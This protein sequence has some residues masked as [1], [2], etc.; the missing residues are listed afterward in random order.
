MWDLNNYCGKFWTIL[1]EQ[2][3]WR[4]KQNK[5]KNTATT[6]TKNK[7]KPQTKITFMLW[8]E[9][10]VFGNTT[11]SLDTL[12]SLEVSV[13]RRLHFHWKFA[14]LWYTTILNWWRRGHTMCVLSACFISLL[15]QYLCKIRAS[16]GATKL[17]CSLPMNFYE[18]G[19]LMAYVTHAGHVHDVIDTD[20]GAQY[21]ITHGRAFAT[22]KRLFLTNRTRSWVKSCC[23]DCF[24]SQ[25]INMPFSSGRL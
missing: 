8:S 16:H 1:R 3:W 13:S 23:E 20:C 21:C 11:K 6:T 9:Y 15:Y 17:V 25:P 19:W 5:N 18:E 10:M 24:N 2:N 7:H 22:F 4:E 14:V 12:F